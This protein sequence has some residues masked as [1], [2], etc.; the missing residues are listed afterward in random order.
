[1]EHT[2]R[3][4]GQDNRVIFDYVCPNCWYQINNCK[5]RFKPYT[6]LFIDENI[7][8]HIR[9]LNTKGYQTRYCCESHNK[10]GGNLIYIS[11]IT[12]YNLELPLGFT[13]DQKHN[14]I[15]YYIKK[16]ELNKF[17]QVKK[18]KLDILLKWC[19]ELPSLID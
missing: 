14:S 4:T 10:K 13:Y 2:E 12:N 3:R 6:L 1:M 5:C 11:F 9:I 15:N 19:K 16:S 8:E 18:E 17:E 7:Q